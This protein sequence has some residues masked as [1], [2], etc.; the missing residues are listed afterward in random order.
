MCQTEQL[1]C[2]SCV[3][4]IYIIINI[5]PPLQVRNLLSACRKCNQRP[6]LAI[7]DIQRRFHTLLQVSDLSSPLP[8]SAQ[9]CP[10]LKIGETTPLIRFSELNFYLL[11]V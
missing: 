8:I 3:F 4:L 11:P 1:T 7:F 5:P 2:A 9:G 10:G 6:H